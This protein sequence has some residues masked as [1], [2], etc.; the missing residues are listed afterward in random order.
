MSGLCGLHIVLQVR[1]H[2]PEISAKAVS[3]GHLLG[4]SLVTP[5]LGCSNA[6]SSVIPA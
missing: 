4:S 2:F 3:S 5:L 6:F 1:K